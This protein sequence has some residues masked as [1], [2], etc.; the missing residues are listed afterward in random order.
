MTNLV[1]VCAILLLLVAF[2]SSSPLFL[3]R[4]S[5]EGISHDHQKTS[6]MKIVREG[7]DSVVGGENVFFVLPAASSELDGVTKLAPKLKKI[8]ASVDEIK[9]FVVGGVD[10]QKMKS[11]LGDANVKVIKGLSNFSED[12]VS[13]G[14]VVVVEIEEGEATEKIDA[15]VSKTM[16]KSKGEVPRTVYL[17]SQPTNAELAQTREERRLQNEANSSDSVYYVAMTP[18][19]LA[20]ILFGFLFVFMTIIGMSCMNDI[21]GQTVFVDKMPHV[22]KE[23]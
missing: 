14:K 6:L 17:A 10:S 20:G 11:L 5:G 7:G 9:H 19:I 3:S 15:V 12:V 8:Q 22:G 2:A 18:N 13:E 23:F 1:C 16:K 4:N 21:E